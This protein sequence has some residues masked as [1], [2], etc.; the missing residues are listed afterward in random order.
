MKGSG[1]QILHEFYWPLGSKITRTVSDTFL[2]YLV[3]I[4]VEIGSLCNSGESPSIDLCHEYTRK[5]K[6]QDTIRKHTIRKH[7]LLPR[8]F[9]EKLSKL[10]T[11]LMNDAYLALRKNFGITFFSNVFGL[12]I[13][14][15]LPWGSHAAQ[16]LYLGFDKI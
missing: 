6:E 9:R 11:C 16:S 2:T 4:G 8:V 10:L 1:I 15:A 7:E 13:L 5:I 12:R 3:I 14:H